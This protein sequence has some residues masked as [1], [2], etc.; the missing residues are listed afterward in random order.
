MLVPTTTAS[1]VAFSPS[2]AERP[3]GGTLAAP[4][5]AVKGPGR[6]PVLTRADIEEIKEAL[7]D[8]EMT[9]GDWAKSH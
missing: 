6:L 7:Y 8:L 9:R 5:E 4:K 2:R 3:S 1:P